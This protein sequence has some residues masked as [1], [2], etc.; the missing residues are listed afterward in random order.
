MPGN[1]RCCGPLA[2]AG[3]AAGAACAWAWGMPTPSR[4]SGSAPP[5]TAPIAAR[6]EL[7]KNLR[8]LV[9]NLLP[10]AALPPVSRAMTSLPCCPLP[11]FLGR[12]SHPETQL[13]GVFA[14]CGRAARPPEAATATAPTGCPTRDCD[15]AANRAQAKSR[16]R[17]GILPHRPT[18]PV[19][20]P[21]SWIRIARYLACEREP[22]GDLPWLVS[23]KLRASLF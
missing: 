18:W 16:N 22:A 12:A 5:M 4:D 1:F 11:G 3:A 23:K 17:C 14:F 20:S 19:R 6:P 15:G 10:S 7:P 2:G 9:S 13:G 21:R 8:R